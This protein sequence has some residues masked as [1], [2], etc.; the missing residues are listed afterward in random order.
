MLLALVTELHTLCTLAFVVLL[1][2]MWRVEAGAVW[3]SI[4][5]DRQ[6]MF[7]ILTNGNLSIPAH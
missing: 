5:L 1:L 3:Q 4:S 7:G 6:K 2:H